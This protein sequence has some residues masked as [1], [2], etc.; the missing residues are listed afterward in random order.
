MDTEKNLQPDKAVSPNADIAGGGPEQKKDEVS[1][2]R[3]KVASNGTVSTAKKPEVIVKKRKKNKLKNWL[4]IT[5]IAAIAGFGLWYFLLRPEASPV[6]FIRF[7]IADKGDITKSV[8][9]TGTLQATTTVQ[10]GSQVSGTIKALHAD[11]NTRVKK[12]DLVAELDPTF[13]EAAVKQAEANYA[14][15]KADLDIAIKNDA[16]NKVL[17]S[18]NLIAKSDNDVTETALADAK[19]TLQQ[20]QASLDQANVN[21]SYTKIHAPISGI[22]TQRSVDVGQTVAA[23]L[24]APVLFIIAEDLAEMEVDAAVDE[25][26]VGQVKQGE[27]VTFTV[28]AFPG[29]KFHGIVKM[30]R[31]NPV[32]T[33]NVVTYTVVITAPNKEEKLFPGMTATVTIVNSAVQDVVRIPAAAIRFTPPGMENSSGTS[34]SQSSGPKNRDSTRSKG[35]TS[36]A[37]KQ[38]GNSGMAVIYRKSNK[39]VKPGEMPELEPIKIKTGISDG[40]LTEVLSSDIPLNIGDS[41]AVGIVVP[42]KTSGSNAPGTNPFGTPPRPGGGATTPRR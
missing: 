10:V 24:S 35:D 29:E 15:A 42:Q 19:A 11:F 14:R 26:D 21:L 18:Q 27:D 23:S 41:I 5:A 8:T 39:P 34:A 6:A 3:M 28:D 9:A 37:G 2:S 12:G 4:M 22:V 1:E 16:R 32:V 31:L 25:A 36:R 13:Y 33:S 7:A 20:L 17:F 40:M 30:V 38:H